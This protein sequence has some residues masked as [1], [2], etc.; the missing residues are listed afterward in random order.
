M[1]K[2]FFF[3]VFIFS[4]F[5][6]TAQQKPR[7]QLSGKITDVKT[8]EPLIGA[9]VILSDSKTGTT[10]DSAGHYVFKNLPVGHTIIEISY[11]GYKTIVEHIE[12]SANDIHNFSL[13]SSIL[14]NEGVT[15]TA[16]ANA[17][18]IRKVPIPITR[19]SKSE[20]LATASTNIIDALSRQPGIS[21]LSTGPAISKPIIRGLGYN[22]LVVINDGVRQ[23][24]Q[25][26]GDEHGIEIDENSVSRVEIVKGPAS[27]IY[28]SDAI[29][30]VINI[31][32]TAPVAI[33][34]LRGNIL[35]NYQT[36]NKQRSFFANLGGNE[37]GFNWNVWGDYKA[38]ADYKN[39]Y[40]GRV[41]N[42][43]FNEHNYG[44]YVG[45][46]NSWGFTHFIVSSFNQELGV[47]EGER[48]M[49]G[50]FIKPVA[51]GGSAVAN[52]ADFNSIDPQIPY[53][54]VAHLKFISD[55]SFKL[56]KGRITL[57]LGWQNN[58]RKEFGNVDAPKINDLFFDLKTFNY[59]VAYHFDDKK[60][61]TSSIGIN[62]MAQS[63]KN[64]SAEVLIPEYN[65]FDIGG[66]IYSQKTFGR[67]TLSGGARFDN[68][69]L[70]SKELKDGID[71]KFSPFKKSFSN[72]STSAGIS[73]AA[74]DNFTLKFN[75]A[76]G[77]RA[78]SIPE[79]A[80]NGAHEGTNRYEY[81][82]QSLKSERS[83]QADFG[84][85][86]N[87]QHIS[88]SANIFYNGISNFIFYSKLP[89]ANSVDSLV[90]V[91]GDLIPAF[92]FGQRNAQLYGAEFLVDLHPHPVD[93][94]HWQN[95][96]SF[97]RGRFDNAIEGVKNLPSIPAARWISEV[98]GE[99]FKKR[100]LFRN[101]AAH[102]EVDHNFQQES[103]FTA[104]G[105][106]TVTSSYTLLN[107]GIS[108][109]IICKNK[110]LFSLYFNAINI[111]DV[112]YQNHLSRLKYTDV[113]VATGRQGVYNSGRNFSV[114]LN[115][116]L[117]LK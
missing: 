12:I 88:A 68:R 5:I 48:D 96:F 38:A 44:G 41:Y 20:L 18:S 33:N 14:E 22:R 16:V 29:A 117:S 74:T 55:N 8:A 59:N 116:P 47:I 114:K 40:D 11:T 52:E 82:D 73:Y 64:K 69:S 6:S 87:S 76:Q 23:E 26:W 70:N 60:G 32:T 35:S 21:Q 83:F 89:G 53:Q 85:E 42:S 103:P 45:Y 54:K 80:S 43:K 30:G 19:V 58:K 100:N 36:N 86:A 10:T 77:F 62:G 3:S 84:L 67:S 34:S 31:V 98:R 71:L 111:G 108:S 46:N 65:L 61:W 90:N 101:V 13:Q 2:L 92:K 49:N 17:T 1:K 97:V 24:G 7:T 51:G 9:S 102:A 78:P 75:L 39:K 112:A 15:I 50:R 99:F 94:M 63:N 37:N 105:T 91:N 56:N 57:N 72:I 81:G 27:L 93:W 113:N 95:T 110:I 66:F 109:N 4:I 106:E 104:Y 25:Q 79:L 107:A 115:I 28:G